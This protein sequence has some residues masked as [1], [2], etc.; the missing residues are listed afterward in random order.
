MQ[1]KTPQ[2][3]AL[4]DPILAALVPHMR[5]CLW[6][7]KHPHCQGEFPIEAG[8]IEFL[9]MLRVPPP[10]FCPTCRRMRRLIHMN[11]TRFFKHACDAPGHSESMISIFPAECPF[12]VYDYQYFTGEKFD[13]FSFGIQ[14]VPGS[15][16][17]TLLELRKVFP[18]PSFLNRDPSSINSEYTNGGRNSKNCYYA[19]GC[20]TAEDVW[21]G[22]LVNRSRMIMDSR[23]IQDSEFVHGSSFSDHLYKVSFAYFSTYC[24]DS[25][26]LFDCRNCTNCFG[27]VNLRNRSYSVFNEQL[28]KEAY[29]EFIRG[30]TPISRTDLAFYQKKFWDLVKSTP[31]N[32]SHNS[33]STDVVG[34]NI[35]HCKNL[36]DVVEAENSE[37]VRHADSALSHKDSMDL[38]FSGGHSH[39]LYGTCNIGS[40]SSHVKFSVSSKFCTDSEFIFNSKNCSNCFMCFGLEN[41]SYCILNTQYE[42]EE[43]FKEVDRIKTEMLTRGEYADGLGFEFSAQA[44]NMSQGQLSYPL[45]NEE[46]IKLGGYV[47]AEP[48]TNVGNLE[49]IA[50]DILPEKITDVDND[51]LKKAIIC[52]VS[53]RPFRIT[54]SELGFYR[55]M[56][57]PLPTLHPSLRLE[58]QYELGAIGKK[59]A[60]TCALCKKLIESLSDP[61]SGFMYYCESCFQTEVV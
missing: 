10:N 32:A 57:L 26:F 24:S 59:Y 15:P 17:G 47:A 45:S 51:I 30:L 48:E 38:L 41:K 22:A 3:D 58:A 56:E 50:A 16:L 14:Y 29:E 20:Y 5:T 27:C 55:R 33:A 36:F 2:F 52:S 4:L 13:A 40:E 39:H 54:E 37:H 44:Y 9:R 6:H 60:T 46:I 31:M 53:G 12:P 19:F 49:V 35:D 28:T 43:Y 1:S 18:M 42:E 34:V 11:Q 7:G 61:A 23:A 21:Y 25:M 8:D